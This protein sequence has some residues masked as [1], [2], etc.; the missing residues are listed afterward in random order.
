MAILKA[1]VSLHDSAL[2]LAFILDILSL[3]SEIIYRFWAC[4]Y[5]SLYFGSHLFKTLAQS[6]RRFDIPLAV[7]WKAMYINSYCP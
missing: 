6:R 4:Y 2:P 7:F 5:R 3:H 1:S